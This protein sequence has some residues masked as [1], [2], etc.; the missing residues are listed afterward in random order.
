[1]SKATGVIYSIGYGDGASKAKAKREE[2]SLE[3]PEVLRD[4]V[5]ALDVTLLDCRA[6]PGPAKEADVVR[7]GNKVRLANGRV[8]YT[9]KGFWRLDLAALLGKRYEWRGDRLGGAWGGSPGPTAAGMDELA[10]DYAAGR[11]VVLMCSEATPRDC[12]RHSLIAVPLAARG[13]I[14]RHVVIFEGEGYVYDAKILEAFGAGKR[15]TAP[16]TC[17]T[18]HV[19]PGK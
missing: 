6:F 16:W 17:L 2:G 13:I 8:I 3:S 9:R 10:A 11:R 1:M 19:T 14:V 5:T 12:H 18:E 7:D 15:K 4:L